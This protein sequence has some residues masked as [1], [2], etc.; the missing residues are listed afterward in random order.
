ME[1]QTKNDR[2][3]SLDRITDLEVLLESFREGYYFP[4]PG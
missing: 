3:D 4:L 2:V 1:T